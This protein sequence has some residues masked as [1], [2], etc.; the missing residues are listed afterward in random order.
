MGV[1]LL[2]RED[3]IL[4]EKEDFKTLKYAVAALGD[5]E[6]PSIE[7]LF[8]E[9]FRVQAKDIDLNDDSVEYDFSDVAW[10]SPEEMSAEELADLEDFL[11]EQITVSG[12]QGWF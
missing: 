7:D 6:R 8:P 11:G 3:R 2:Q 5:P 4:A 12:E 10:E 1:W 9:Y